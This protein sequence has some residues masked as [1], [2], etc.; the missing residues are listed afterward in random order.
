[1]TSPQ[2]HEEPLVASVDKRVA[3]QD[4]PLAE[5]VAPDPP[6]PIT[7]AGATP[8]NR[9]GLDA[10]QDSPLFA[11][12][13]LGNPGNPTSTS[14]PA[15]R[16][17][18]PRDASEITILKAVVPLT[19]TMRGSRL[20]SPIPRPAD[21]RSSASAP[22]IL[23]LAGLAS[24]PPPAPLQPLSQSLSNLID[25]DAAQVPTSNTASTQNV[26]LTSGAS[27]QQIVQVARASSAPSQQNV[28]V[29]PTS[30]APAQQNVSNVGPT[31][32]A[33]AQQNVG[34]TSIPAAPASSPP[35]C[36]QSLPDLGPDGRASSSPPVRSQPPSQSRSNWIDRDAAREPP[37]NAPAQIKGIS[38]FISEK[39]NEF[40]MSGSVKPEMK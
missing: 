32:S 40:Q 11:L 12:E 39:V 22:G 13:D 30:S 18:A 17:P 15:T 31:S 7:A 26:A 10:R 24:S 2:K 20:R 4:E 16:P 14:L 19:E 25:P 23:G 36:L 38:S 1:M 5:D 8:I 33:P 6:D 9:A 28:Q 27:A 21:S 34:P 3:G 37:P 29:G 35:A